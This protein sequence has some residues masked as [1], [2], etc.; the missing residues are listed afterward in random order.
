M[1]KIDA[2]AAAAR[3]RARDASVGIVGMG[4]VG[5]P[6]MLAATSAGFRVLGFHGD[7]PKASALTRGKSPLKR[8]GDGRIAAVRE[9]GLLE[10]TARCGCLGE[11]DAV[12]ICVPT[13]LGPH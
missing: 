7:E 2:A 13:P 6:L 10:A 9:K 4:Y 1:A 8:V 3:F 11:P 12:L 5:L